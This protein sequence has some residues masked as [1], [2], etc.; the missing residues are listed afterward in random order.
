VASAN[1]PGSPYEIVLRPQ[2][3]FAEWTRYAT[4]GVNGLGL[5]VILSTAIAA[6][7]LTGPDG[8]VTVLSIALPIAGALAW[9]P[10]SVLPNHYVASY[11]WDAAY[12]LYSP[13]VLLAAIVTQNALGRVLA[14]IIAAVAL[15]TPV[16]SRP[17]YAREDW[18]LQNQSRQKRL[19]ERLSSLIQQLPNRESAI[20]V[21]G[22]SFPFSPFDHWR[23][24]LSMKPPA[25]ARFYVVT[26]RTG[27]D[28]LSP[29]R[30]LDASDGTVTRIAPDLVRK[31]HF[32]HAWLFNSN[33]ELI[34]NV[35]DPTTLKRWTGEGFDGSDLLAYPELCNDFGPH[36][37][38]RELNKA[39]GYRYLACGNEF[40]SY[41]N[42]QRAEACLQLSTHTILDNPYP[43]FFLGVALERQGK[44][45]DA[46]AAYERAVAL[47]STS[48]NPAF[49][50]ALEKLK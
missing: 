10:N 21:S 19:M 38:D 45:A 43:Y 4:A 11:S 35:A 48:P 44:V 32:D 12:L 18:I 46:R 27:P 24:I 1:F 40:L 17:T 16:L 37:A 6:C 13:V 20:L 41:E 30:K 33:G 3:V 23:A 39:P 26:Y 8:R 28:G 36:A 22:F 49:R 29:T 34:Q 42:P 2:S 14:L 5:A 50:A 47:E 15:S 7:L 25:G 31:M 9:L